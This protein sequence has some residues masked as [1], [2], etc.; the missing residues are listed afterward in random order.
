MGRFASG[1]T[2]ITTRA[3][4]ADHGTT[5]S[6]VSSLSMEPPMV[7]VCLNQT[8]VTQAAVREAA[9]FAVNILGADQGDIAFQFATKSGSEKFEGVDVAR[10][11]AT[12][13]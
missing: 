5:A 9:C 3:G 13:R 6:A 10:A 4:G 12:C 7:L 11:G 1:V 8:S 2:V